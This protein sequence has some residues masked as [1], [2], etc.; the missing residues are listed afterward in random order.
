MQGSHGRYLWAGEGN[1]LLAAQDQKASFQPPSKFPAIKCDVA[2]ALPADLPYAEVEAAL[3][4]VGG[5]T[6]VDLEL[7]D[8]YEEGAL[9]EQGLRSLAFHASLQAGDRTLSD[10][11]EQKFLRKI[12]DAAERLGGSLRS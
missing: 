6:L 8:V 7:F 10:K 5:K 4:K 12:G 11:D 9:A 1:Q 2:L 3:R